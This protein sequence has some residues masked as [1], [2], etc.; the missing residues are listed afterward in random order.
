MKAAK[1]LL[2]I[3]YSKYLYPVGMTIPRPVLLLVIP[4]AYLLVCAFSAGLL[5]YPLHFILPSTTK[6]H[7]LVFTSAQ[8]LLFVGLIPLGRSLG[9]QRAA[10]GLSGDGWFIVRQILRGFSYGTLMLGAHMLLLILLDIRSLNPE[11]L[12]FDTLYP[13]LQKSIWVG[14]G[15]ALTEEPLFRGFLL[16]ALYRY[17]DKLSAI[18]IASAYF[19]TLH[20]LRTDQRPVMAEVRWDT[21]LSLVADAFR[22]IAQVQWDAW[23][24]LFAAGAFLGCVRLLQPAANLGLCF[25]I[26][27]GW[28]FIIKTSNPL[29]Q[30]NTDSPWHGWVSPMDNTIG[31]FSAAWTTVLIL[32]LAHTMTRN[33]I[34]P[35]G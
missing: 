29:S 8:I 33:T 24:A 32:W 1:P 30:L 18:V 21:G 9:I 2:L 16:G 17:S 11:K 3:G 7:G 12:Q 20:F 25:G 13:L 26:H 34:T 4:L 35:K 15:V 28:V 23:L 22:H 19:A 27:A 10:L 31:Y 14:F 5:A 6:F